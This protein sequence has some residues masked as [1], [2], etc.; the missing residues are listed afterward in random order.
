MYKYRRSG[1]VHKLDDVQHA[2]GEMW[3]RCG[4]L[5][6]MIYPKVKRV[7]RHSIVMYSGH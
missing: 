1:G 3:V 5:W 4:V 6:D 7:A 2:M